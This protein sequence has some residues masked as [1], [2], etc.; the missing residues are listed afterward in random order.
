MVAVDV[1]VVPV[2]VAVDVEVVG[3]EVVV[4]IVDVEVVTGVEVVE[5]DDVVIVGV[6]V[7]VEVDDVN[8]GVTVDDEVDVDIVGVDVVDI[9]DVVSVDVAVGVAEVVDS[10]EVVADVDV[11]DDVGEGGRPMVVSVAR[12]E[13][14]VG[15]PV[16]PWS[17]RSFLTRLASVNTILNLIIVLDFALDDLTNNSFKAVRCSNVTVTPT[18]IAIAFP[19]SSTI[20]DVITKMLS[21]ASTV[22]IVSS[23][24]LKAAMSPKRSLFLLLL[25]PL[26]SAFII[27]IVSSIAV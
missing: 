10:V 8:I 26:S 15:S 17:S 3:V 23:S 11:D 5:D 14:R 21:L 12:L 18:L 9:V 24:V 2:D 16:T 19:L 4:D 25:L 22:S 13:G 7:D 6:T 27:A 1:E 20:K